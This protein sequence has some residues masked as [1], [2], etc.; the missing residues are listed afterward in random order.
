VVYLRATV[1]LGG[2]QI[3]GFLIVDI[4]SALSGDVPMADTDD[5]ISNGLLPVCV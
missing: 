4:H 2:I 5:N 3:L 1:G